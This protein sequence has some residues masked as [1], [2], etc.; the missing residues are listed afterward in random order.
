MGQQFVQSQ[1]KETSVSAMKT[2]ILIFSTINSSLIL[3]GLFSSPKTYQNVNLVFSAK[4][5][6]VFTVYIFQK[7]VS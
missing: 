3:L 2:F 1:Q 5:L 7:Q 6:E 4:Q